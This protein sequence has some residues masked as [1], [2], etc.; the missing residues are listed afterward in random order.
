MK[1][2]GWK[3]QPLGWLLLFVIVIILG[4]LIT[5]W[6]RRQLPPPETGA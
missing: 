1:N 3:I 4:N 6:V 2:V 5:K